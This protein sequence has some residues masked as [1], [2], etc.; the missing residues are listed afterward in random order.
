MPRFPNRNIFEL[1]FDPSIVEAVWEKAPIVAGEDPFEFRK[2]CCGAWIKKRSFGTADSFGWEIDHIKP[3][4]QGG[5]DDP[6]NLQPLHWRNNRG[7]G[8]L[9]PR[10]KATLPVKARKAFSAGQVERRAGWFRNGRAG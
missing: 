1:P 7:K 2:D 10:W 3:V 4:S 9:F 5:T 6:E 8:D